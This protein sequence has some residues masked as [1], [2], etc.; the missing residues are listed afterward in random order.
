MTSAEGKA[1]R[2]DP[3]LMGLWLV[4]LFISDELIDEVQGDLEEIFQDRVECKGLSRARMHYFKDAVLSIRNANLRRKRKLTQNNSYPMVKNYVKTTFRTLAKNKVY[5]ALNIMGLA[6][7][8]AACL[9]IVQY[10]DYEYSYD[11]F[12]SNH[13]N[14]YRVKYMVYRSGNLDIDCAA[15]VPRVG[16]FM[17]ENM[18]EVEDFVRAFPMQEIFE[19]NNIQYRESRVQ[20]VDPSFLTMFD[21]PLIHG[22]RESALEGPYK[23]VITETTAKKYFGKSDVVGE[24]L[25]MHSW[26]IDEP[27]DFEITGV[28]AD[29]PNNSHLKYNILV[30]YETIN[31]R[32]RNDDGTI[33]SENAWG[34]YDFNTY[35]SLRDGVDPT[36]FDAKFAEVLYEERKEDF[37]K[38][39]FRADFPL[40]P[41]TDIH[42]YSNLLQES[43]PQEQ[44][45]GDTV[46]F[47]S[48]IAIFILVIAWIN[49]I[50][51]STAKSLER[52][53]EV[54]V[55]KSMGAH[56]R[57]LINQFL[58]ES[59]VLNVI[60][61]TLAIGIVIIFTP[62]FG[63]LVDIEFTRAFFTQPKFWVAVVSILA[64][65]SILSGVYPAF[66]LSSFRPIEVL[67]G[68]LTS[69][70]S[71]IF[72]R[73][74][75]V[76]FQFAASVTLIAG[77][78]IVY[79]QLRH[80]KTHDLGFEMTD[81]FVMEGPNRG[82]STYSVRL[83]SFYSDLESRSIIGGVAG[84]SNVPGSEIFWTRGMRQSA[85]TEDK[86]VICYLVGVDNDY[87]PTLDIDIVAGRNYDQDITTDTVNV[88][89]NMSTVRSLKISSPEEAIGVRIT[90]GGDERTIIGVVDDY[91]QL[92]LKNTINPLV[93]PLLEDASGYIITKL[94]TD[95]YQLAL[96]EI[97]ESYDEFFPSSP[98]DTFFLD[99]FYNRQYVNEQNF[100]QA[101]TL[102]AL[103]AIIVACLGL[104]GLTSFTALQRTKEIGIRKV[105][106]AEVSQLVMIL[107][108]EF[109]ILVGI[110]NVISWPIVFLIMN[111]W[112]NTFTSRISIGIPVFLVSAILVLLIA[113][114]SV[115][116]KTLSTAKGNPIK[117]LRYE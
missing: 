50:N 111:G 71:G 69:N 54:G 106:G 22:D 99:E 6:L 28:T 101:F 8:L 98:F 49:Y 10:V 9:F 96:K 108:K 15:A 12:H 85:D 55:R 63:R 114:I 61:L 13:E 14:I 72:L 57:Q 47:L 34:W 76:V 37:E 109:M 107:S 110:A 117:A 102:F 52:A 103:F 97:K 44:G 66:V 67:K 19:K 68:K 56:R 100:S 38:Y 104:F 62:L 17:K 21:Y 73:R 113:I 79:Q 89:V 7:G 11:K 90:V 115:G 35:V 1:K 24:T 23:L 77:T 94:N 60:A 42:L 51:L 2:A 53:K 116:Y 45:D 64:L 43:E 88:I 95:N 112:L 48:M 105:L 18:P 30:S 41:I 87:F 82:D 86:N 75:L 5:S 36:E 92:S 26:L 3:P 78:L 83:K 31:S 25:K 65:G 70:H 16:P 33:S 93:F 4:Q 29:V 59:F 91:Q 58:V 84:G 20:V 74:G 27:K 32:T 46:F 39:D 81:T 80:M 40:Q